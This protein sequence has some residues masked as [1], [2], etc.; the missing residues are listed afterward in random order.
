MFIK[1]FHFTAGLKVNKIPVIIGAPPPPEVREKRGRRMFL[2]GTIDYKGLPRITPSKQ[3]L[4]DTDP[5]RSATVDDDDN[6]NDDYD[7]DDDDDDDDD[8]PLV[9]PQRKTRSSGPAVPS[10][11][12]M[13]AIPPKPA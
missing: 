10:T 9:P 2:N 4:A 11:T 8:Q 5:Q 12:I 13:V 6:N 1:R 7:D 3:Q